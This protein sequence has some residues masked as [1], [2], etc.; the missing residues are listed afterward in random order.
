VEPEENLSKRALKK[1]KEEEQIFDSE[2]IER[3]N[4]E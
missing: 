4:G 2:F 3:N 1:L